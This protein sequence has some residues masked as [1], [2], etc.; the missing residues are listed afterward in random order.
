M[1]GV[2]RRLF[3]YGAIDIL[4]NRLVAMSMKVQSPLVAPPDSG[5]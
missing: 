5:W 4:K 2:W 1:D 3:R